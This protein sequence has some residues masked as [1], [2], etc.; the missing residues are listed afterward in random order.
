MGRDVEKKLRIKSMLEELSECFFEEEVI[1]RDLMSQLFY[2][3]F[4]FFLLGVDVY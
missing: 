3:T 1:S 4:E 2:L